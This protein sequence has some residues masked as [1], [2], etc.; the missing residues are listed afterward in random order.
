MRFCFGDF[1]SSN[2]LDLVFVHFGIF[3]LAAIQDLLDRQK[4]HKFCEIIENLEVEG[5]NFCADIHI[6]QVKLG[7]LFGHLLAFDDCCGWVR[8]DLHW[9]VVRPVQLRQASGIFAL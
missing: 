1:E 5:N 3:I 2:R 4:R 6:R 8:R 7:L 9:Q